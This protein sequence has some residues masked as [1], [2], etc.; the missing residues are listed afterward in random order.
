MFAAVLPELFQR[1]ARETGV[2]EPLS[3]FGYSVAGMTL[4]ATGR[5]RSGADRRHLQ[6]LGTVFFLLV[7]EEVDYLGIFGGVI[8]RVDGVYVGSPHD[9][10]NLAAAGLL[11]PAVALVLVG[12]VA[13][14]AGAAWKAG[15]LQPMRLARTLFSGTGLWLLGGGI[16]L[17]TGLAE[18]AYLLDLGPVQLEELLELTGVVLLLVFTLEVARAAASEPRIDHVA[19]NRAEGVRQPEVA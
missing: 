3:L 13:A 15:F 1:W 11:S 9:L 19:E 17:F 8:G 5:G 12:V 6:F 14:L 2:F 10:V 7:L 4:F 16:L 18:D